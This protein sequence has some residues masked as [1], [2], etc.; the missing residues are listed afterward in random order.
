VANKNFDIISIGDATI[1]HFLLFHDASVNCSLDKNLC[2]LCLNYADKLPVDQY[3]KLVAGNAANNAVGS[4]RLGLK[5]A[6]YLELG[7]D[8]AGRKI[9]QQLEVEGV[10]SRYIYLR[11][12]IETNN[13]FVLSFQGERTIMVYH[14]KR[15]YVLPDM[16]PAEWVYLTSTGHGY[17]ELFPD[18]ID[19]VKKN[20][21][22][23]A[24]NPGTFQLRGDKNLMAETLKVCEVVF[25]NIEEAQQ[26]LGTTQK[27]VSTLLSGMRDLGPAT[28]VITDGPKGAYAYDGREYLYLPEFSIDRVETT[29]AGDSFATGFVAALQHGNTMSEAL[30]WGSFNAS[31]VVMHIGPQEGLLT[32][33]AMEQRLAAN[34]DYKPMA[35]KADTSVPVE[36]PFTTSVNSHRI[37]TA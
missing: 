4:S 15:Q 35:F 14:V 2:Q 19:Y 27:N 17:E 11:P 7:D 9:K 23:L 34:T 33:Q 12:D 28:V 25:I 24:Y 36:P 6:Y 37:I 1:D 18:V 16:A 8:E 20:A 13:S 29:G 3:I 22:K 5:T 21:V 32:K 10:D 26:I 31:S 30:R